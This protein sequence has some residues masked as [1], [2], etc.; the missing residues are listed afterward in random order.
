MRIS[1]LP[2]LLFLM[3]L[4]GCTSKE[5]ATESHE[6]V[7]LVVLGTVQDGG[8]PHIGCQKDCCR[9]LFLHPDETRK[10]VS[11]GLIDYNNKKT[12]IFEATPDFPEQIA[13]LNRTASFE[14]PEIPDGVFLTHAHI[15]HYTGL[16]YLGREAIGSQ[17]TPVH[18]M[19]RMKNFL[20]TSGPWSQL[21]S[22]NNININPLYNDSTI[23]LS[24]TLHVTPFRVP[25]RD[26]YSETVGFRISGPDKT[27]LFIPDIDKWSKW[28]KDIVREIGNVDMVFIDATFFDGNEINRDM[29][30]IPHP[31]VVESMQLLQS[32]TAGEK[33]KVHF[34]HFN[35]TNALLDPKSQSFKTVT[36]EGFQIARFGQIIQ[37]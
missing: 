10:V 11:L 31:F 1:F 25:H 30:E 24:S 12:Y 17:N 16:M 8:S 27:I 34:I 6:G 36:D 26:E 18:A 19:P 32:L 9:E 5:V 13:L 15:G 2:V 14:H 23:E 4:A 3:I 37:L 7:Q 28:D 21:V 29:S 20:E 22:L 33:K 35:H